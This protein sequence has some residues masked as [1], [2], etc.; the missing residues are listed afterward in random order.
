[1]AELERVRK[2]RGFTLVE[3]LVCVGLL[4][5]MAAITAHNFLRGA[6]SIKQDALAALSGEIRSLQQRS[7][8]E[9]K[10]MALTLVGPNSRKL[11]VEVGQSLPKLEKVRDFTSDFGDCWL[12]AASPSQLTSPDPRLSDAWFRAER[13]AII[14]T[15]AGRIYSN[16]APD[17][18][19][20]YHVGLVRGSGGLWDVRLHSQGDIRLSQLS[21]DRNSVPPMNNSLSLTI[22]GNN[23]PEIK[24]LEVL[25][26]AAQPR[27]S[28]GV[29]H[30]S[31]A[32]GELVTFRIE[33]DDA[34]GDDQLVVRGEGA[35]LFSS[36]L[37]AP[38]SYDAAQQRWIGFLTWQ[39]PNPVASGSELRFT[40][41]D[42]AGAIA[43][44]NAN[45][46]TILDGPAKEMLVFAAKLSSD[47]KNRIYRCNPDGSGRLPIFPADDDLAGPALS[48][49]G[50]MLAYW[51]CSTWPPRLCV[52]GI[53]GASQRVLDANWA[54]NGNMGIFWSADSS[55]VLVSKAPGQIVAYPAAGGTP[56]VVASGV[57]PNLTVCSPDHK[58]LA[59][60]RSGVSPTRIEI[61]DL[62]SG[63]QEVVAT[64]VAGSQL[65]MSSCDSPIA[66]AGDSNT[67]YYCSYD[68]VTQNSTIFAYTSPG[69]AVQVLN[70]G[71]R[72]LWL[73]GGPGRK[74]AHVNM[75]PQRNLYSYLDYTDVASKKLVASRI[76]NSLYAG[77]PDRFEISPDGERI[78]WMQG[79]D[80][81]SHFMRYAFDGADPLEISPVGTYYSCP[82]SNGCALFQPTP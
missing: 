66:F 3:I 30:L 42:R 75:S 62:Q 74:L 53:N 82:D 46:K 12:N 9:N 17:S 14:F 16:L 40:V 38:M 64:T 5:G 23:A 32:P 33:A 1:M 79:L 41:T 2:H 49:Q 28:N 68:S 56:T 24:A 25:N 61:L 76:S 21:P 37:A 19:G 34:D 72:V 58:K 13:V 63:A 67:L 77:C 65:M 43:S 45:S 15:P 10:I 39:P 55:R 47:P 54:Q 31:P 57:T 8:Q 7:V 11:G 35:G 81:A 70:A 78:Y 36:A 6:T 18:D 51:N 69:P 52:A 29:V 20:A 59:Y 71:G 73:R 27:D 60:F 80:A 50:T 22:A 48:P 26:S 44:D 4:L